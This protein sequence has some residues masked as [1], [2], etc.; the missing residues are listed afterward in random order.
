MLM[1]AMKMMR[2]E[3]MA[4]EIAADWRQRPTEMADDDAVEIEP[5]DA[6]EIVTS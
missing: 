1:M 3:S 6:D 4:K 2:R 5:D